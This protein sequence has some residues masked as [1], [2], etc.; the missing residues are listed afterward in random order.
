MTRTID[1]K[2]KKIKVNFNITKEGFIIDNILYPVKKEF[3]EI[4]CRNGS[5][6]Y[7]RY[8]T[9]NGVRIPENDKKIIEMIYEY[10]IK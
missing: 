7:A 4:I 9:F 8:Q 5:N 2:G 3:I 1:F 10:K 6:G